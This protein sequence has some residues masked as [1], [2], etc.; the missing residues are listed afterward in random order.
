MTVRKATD[1]LV[2]IGLEISLQYVPG[3]HPTGKRCTSVTNEYIMVS[4]GY[5]AHEDCD[6]FVFYESNLNL[7]SS[8]A[9]FLRVISKTHLASWSCVATALV[10]SDLSIEKQ[11]GKVDPPLV[12]FNLDFVNHA[13][14]APVKLLG[15]V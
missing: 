2:F 13:R 5:G 11:V 3:L 1:N 9:P 8:L 10:G 4:G 15:K 7:G 6:I 14:P 12:L